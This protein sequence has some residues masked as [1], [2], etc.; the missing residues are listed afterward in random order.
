MLW[1]YVVAILNSNEGSTC[2]LSVG[3]MPDG[4]AYFSSFYVCF[5][6]LKEGWIEGC[7]R[8]I[9]PDGCFL[10]TICKGELLSTIGRDECLS[11][12]LNNETKQILLKEPFYYTEITRKWRPQ[13]EVN[14]KPTF[15]SMQT[16]MGI[17]AKRLR[18][19]HVTCAIGFLKMA[20]LKEIMP[21]TNLVAAMFCNHLSDPGIRQR[22]TV[23]RQ[24][25][26]KPSLS[27]LILSRFTT[28]RDDLTTL[29]LR[30]NGRIIRMMEMLVYALE[31]PKPKHNHVPKAN[32]SPPNPKGYTIP[33]DKRLATGARG[34]QEGVEQKWRDLS[35][36]ADV[37][38]MVRA[39]PKDFMATKK[40]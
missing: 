2:K 38:T 25:M 21:P 22:D 20:T 3:H 18:L 6:A 28:R 29:N 16:L 1:S 19:A 36:S 17:Y 37:A 13:K 14:L 31:L 10:K 9:G 7:K 35:F 40:E 8:V 33:L 4:K 34:L 15:S 27:K 39:Q 26:R 32:G 11:I 23:L 12:T 30:A 24:R 5:K